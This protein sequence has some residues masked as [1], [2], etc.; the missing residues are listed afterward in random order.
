MGILG[1]IGQSIKT[2]RPA[3]MKAIK[4][5]G[6]GKEPMVVD[7]SRM[8]QFGQTRKELEGAGQHHGLAR[9]A[10]TTGSLPALVPADL[11]AEAWV[12]NSQQP[13]IQVFNHLK[14][15][16][17]ILVDYV[18]RDV[19]HR[20]LSDGEPGHGWDRGTIL[21]TDLAGFTPLLEAHAADSRDGAI[22]LLDLINQY[23][24]VMAEIASKSGGSL[25]E[26]TG[27]A[28]LI[29]FSESE[30]EHH[31]NHA[32]R[33][34]L[35]MQR[36]MKDFTAIPTEQGLLSLKM[37]IG[38]HSGSFLKAQIGTPL[39][40]GH[41]L[42]GRTVQRAKQVEA[43]GR[44]GQV[45]IS[46]TTREVLGD[47]STVLK[48]LGQ[49][50]LVSHD[51][52]DDT[53]GNFDISFNRRRLFSPMLLDSSIEGVCDA[54]QLALPKIE[55][56][57]CYI[58]RSVLQV[59]V[60]NAAVRQ[61]MMPSF[62]T[63]AVAFVNLIGLHEAVDSVPPESVDE[64][65]ACFSKVFTVINGM[66]ES[67]GGILQKLTY[68][69]VGSEMLIHFGALHPHTTDAQRAARAMLAIRDRISTL[70]TPII[71]G[72][73]L[74]LSSRIGLTYGPVFSAEIGEPKGRREFNVLG[75]TVNTAARL[76]GQAKK[77]Q[78]LL[79]QAMQTQVA[80]EF[81]TQSLGV[82]SLKGKSKA[83][84]IYSLDQPC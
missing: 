40:M 26:F 65:V 22:A 71:N 18:P 64:V 54:I 38:L 30:S 50:W 74:K 44:S 5:L 27:D 21:F 34:G 61:T 33:A 19:S 20:L 84:A 55:S 47:D 43:G 15:L 51:G 11:F 58:P 59:L 29:Q 9:L 16:Y 66:V 72:Q 53:L 76:M 25:V 68:H 4:R 39:R 10:A 36:A 23:F 3:L 7:L 75:N 82:I 45:A 48:S 37:R 56:L 24:A 70:E 31:A 6:L 49:H 81:Q 73:P 1:K 12:S 67:Q 57:A 78:I 46:S 8:A 60:A 35:R 62:P 14:T 2:A 83:E 63:I 41:V 69:A 17:R 52:R 13:L 32:V 42:L 79:D 80:A 28:L 77:N